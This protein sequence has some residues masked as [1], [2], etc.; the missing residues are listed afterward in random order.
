MKIKT[1]IEKIEEA[2]SAAV[3]K[4]NSASDNEI[5]KYYSDLAKEL[6]SWYKTLITYGD[7][8]YSFK[9][10]TAPSEAVGEKR[11]VIR[12]F[13]KEKE[14]VDIYVDMGGGWVFAYKKPNEI[15]RPYI[16]FFFN[17]KRDASELSKIIGVW[18]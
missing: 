7:K 15:K 13:D 8:P 16:K 2:S 4:Y 3:G 6:T 11:N 10:T 17:P 5:K 14:I 18:G 12:V 9:T 1:F